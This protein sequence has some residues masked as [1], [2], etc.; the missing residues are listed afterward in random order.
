MER[1]YTII[2]WISLSLLGFAFGSVF[3]IAHHTWVDLSVLDHCHKLKPSI[4]LDDEG[5]EW[6]RFSLDKREP[7]SI[8]TMPKHLINA[9][10]AAEDH[11]FFKHPGI[12]WRG[13]IRSMLVN[14]YRRKVVQGASTITQQLVKLLFFDQKRTFS[15]KIKEQITALFVE[16]QFTKEEILEA[17][18]NNVCFGCGIYGVE[19]ACER[20]WAKH[21]GDISISEAATLAAVVRSPT[22]YCPLLHPAAT[23]KRRNIILQSMQKLRF[24]SIAECE[25]AKTVT[26]TTKSE[27]SALAPHLRE[28]I[29]IYLEDL[30]GREKLYG[31]G[32]RIKT[33]LNQE[34]QKK[35]QE[36]F[37]AQIQQ[38]RKKLS[39]EVD[40]GLISLD[41]STGAIKALIGGF[42]FA[43]SQFNRALQAQRQMGSL[44]KPVIY[45]AAIEK[46]M[47]F[48]DV[49][50]DEP[51]EII[52][53]N[54]HWTPENSYERFEGAM[55]L[56]QALSRSNN[57]IAIKTLLS[58]GI[59][60]V[61]ERVQKMGIKN[62]VPLYPSLALGCID[63]SLCQSAAMLNVFANGGTYVEPYCIQCI[64]DEWSSQIWRANPASVRVF[65]PLISDQVSKVLMNT[66]ERMSLRY[67]KK[68]LPFEA[69]GKTGT[70]NQCR[71]CMLIGCTPQLT[72]GIYIGRDD[73]GSLGKNI[74][75]YAT[76]WPIWY[77]L[78]SAIGSKPAQFSFD[79]RL[80]EIIVHEKTGHRLYSSEEKGA[81]RILVPA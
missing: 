54:R 1:L 77:A 45:A 64:K 41:V 5:N 18:L 56:A 44:I 60:S 21:V 36:I 65:S 80:R 15:R 24:I 20:F 78:H 49:E 71:T 9:F 3:F 40:G 17:Y 35:A 75:G 43:S 68:L 53:N 61:A 69:F 50:I 8:I 25:E 59:N 52:F 63:I 38:L 76:A 31:G 6:A 14:L 33:T 39:K 27:S 7:V 32:L 48:D 67:A 46:G 74:F 81:F 23:Q 13:I 10:I 79:P 29:R 62:S 57:T 28:A 58:V 16:R 22:N 73:N 51:I 30:L 47:R 70:T 2:I 12:S 72:T 37:S 26:V 34:L 66:I 4:L 11:E 19:A 55:T 42:D